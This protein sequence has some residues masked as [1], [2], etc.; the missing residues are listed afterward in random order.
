MNMPCFAADL[1]EHVTR[2]RCEHA[3]LYRISLLY[4]NMLPVP[5]VNMPYFAAYCR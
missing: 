5:G 2:I 1:R 3:S 4:V